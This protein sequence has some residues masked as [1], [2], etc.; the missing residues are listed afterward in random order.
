MCND[1]D[2]SMDSFASHSLWHN[3]APKHKNGDEPIQADQTF[4]PGPESF[5]TD[6]CTVPA[7]RGDSAID[8]NSQETNVWSAPDWE[9]RELHEDVTKIS[10]YTRDTM[11]IENTTSVYDEQ[12]TYIDPRQTLIHSSGN[13]TGVTPQSS[14]QRP[15]FLSTG[16][17]LSARGNTSIASTSNTLRSGTKGQQP[18]SSPVMPIEPLENRTCSNL[19]Q[20]G[21]AEG[22]KKRT[23]RTRLPRDAVERFREWFNEHDKYP[24][25]SVDDTAALASETGTTTKQV[26]AWFSNTRTRRQQ[27]GT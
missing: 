7:Y 22:L 11:M 17:L 21:L 27:Q 1:T 14:F 23:R 15:T 2:S 5:Q 9:A 19:D 13:A 20:D 18:I 8:M 3:W 4:H 24:Y 6:S 12:V 10:A 16:G 26:R 25:P